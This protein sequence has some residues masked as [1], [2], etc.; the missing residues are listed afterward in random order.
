MLV[1][2]PPLSASVSAI[3]VPIAQNAH[4]TNPSRHAVRIVRP[5][6]TSM[7]ASTVSAN[8]RTSRCLRNSWRA[9]L[10]KAFRCGCIVVFS[11]CGFC[12]S[13]WRSFFLSACNEMRNVFSKTRKLC[14]CRSYCSSGVF[15]A[16]KKYK[17]QNIDCMESQRTQRSRTHV[18]HDCSAC[19]EFRRLTLLKTLAIAF[20]RTHSTEMSISAAACLELSTFANLTASFTKCA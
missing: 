2:L 1:V 15:S 13:S 3:V 4:A 9:Q 16:H 20:A 17:P 6:A 11:D 5:N 8:R 10:V 19:V 7:P 18:Q 14:V 12:K